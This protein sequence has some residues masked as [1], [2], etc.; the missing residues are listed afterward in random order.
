[1]IQK[2]A[3]RFGYDAPTQAALDDFK[4]RRNTFV[5]S[6][7]RVP[8]FSLGSPDGRL[9]GATFAVELGSDARAL[10]SKLEPLI[11]EWA[12]Q[13]GVEPTR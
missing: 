1:M 7:I 11:A 8:G 3:T 6:L 13:V 9:I 12:R 2:A 5:H 4:D 10:S